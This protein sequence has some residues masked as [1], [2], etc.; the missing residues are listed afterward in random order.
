V[1]HIIIAG[2]KNEHM[3]QPNMINVRKKKLAHLLD[4]LEGDPPA[5]SR[6]GWVLI[7]R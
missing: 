7:R 2:A 5:V 6:G 4:R 1:K 3:E